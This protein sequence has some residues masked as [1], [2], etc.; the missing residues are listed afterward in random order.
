MSSIYYHS[1]WHFNH[2]FVAKTRNFESAEEHDEV[3]IENINKTVR[4]RDQLWV[5]GDLHMGSLTA[6]LE[7]IKRVN[8]AK[9]LVLGNHDAGHP[10]HARSHTYLKRY[11]EVFDSVSVHEQH[12]FAG[13]KIMLSHLPYYGD[14]FNA[15]R[16]DDWRL[17]DYGRW[18]ICGH[19]HQEW[20]IKDKQ[21]NV[22][23]DWYPQPVSR[24]ALAS[25]IELGS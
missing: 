17:R 4:K 24:N 10:M 1:D 6:A 14:H 16:F 12:A 20:A 7:K 13:H 2:D 25:V 21:I 23:V 15:D 5:L 18:L 9:H 11:M 22:G 8:G 3:L 19:V